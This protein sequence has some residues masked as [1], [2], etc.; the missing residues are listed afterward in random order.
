[1]SNQRENWGCG[2]GWIGRSED[3]DVDED[4]DKDKDE[5]WVA[6]LTGMKEKV[7][8]TTKMATP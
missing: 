7:G 2:A 1:M 3:A 6:G 8:V 5:A 4:E